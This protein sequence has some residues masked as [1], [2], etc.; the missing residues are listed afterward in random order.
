MN[1]LL[2]ENKC[3]SLYSYNHPTIPLKIFLYCDF[4]L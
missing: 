1:A 3:L 4:C 2:A